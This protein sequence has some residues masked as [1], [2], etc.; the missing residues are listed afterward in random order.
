MGTQG[1]TAVIIGAAQVPK[2]ARLRPLLAEKPLVIC[3]DGGLDRAKTLG[4]TPDWYVG[5]SDSG[6]HPPEGL[7]NWLLPSEKALTDLEMGVQVALEQGA[8][9][10]VLCGCTGGRADH[11]LANLFLLEQLARRG[12]SAWLVD[13]VNLVTCLLPGAY[14]VQNHMRHRYFGLI[15]L[16]RTL[17]GVTLTGCKYP[18]E[19]IRVE[20]GST[21][22]ISNEFLPHTVAEIRLE[23]GAALLI[24]SQPEE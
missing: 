11:H 20:R 18:V 14:Q 22:T 6:G 23:A 10:V 12:V 4:L 17:E 7:P 5:D 16:D 15:P 3:A 19:G 2:L 24:C 21:L 9:R 1:L 13:E 8:D